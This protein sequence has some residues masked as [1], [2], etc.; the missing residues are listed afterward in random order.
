MENFFINPARGTW[1]E[2]LKR[3]VLDTRSLEERVSAILAAVKE[4]GDSA[5]IKYTAQ[6]DGVELSCLQ[7]TEAEFAQAGSLVSEELKQAI[8]I[9]RN[10][11]YKF[12]YTQAEQSQQ[13][14]TMEGVHCWRKSVPIQ[15]VGLYIPGGTAPLFS[16]L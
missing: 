7:V 4:K 12:H 15:K 9:A 14:E 10:N 11:I 2:L 1:Q 6:F 8:D 5:V 13:V 16:T 3:P